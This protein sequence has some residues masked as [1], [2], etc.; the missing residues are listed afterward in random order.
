MPLFA[1]WDQLGNGPLVT[2]MAIVFIVGSAIGGVA[3]FVLGL[4]KNAAE[5]ANLKADAVRNAGD[6]LI[7]VQE[8]RQR[9]VDATEACAGA[10]ANLIELLKRGDT[11]KEDLNMAREEV[12][13]LFAYRVITN[14]LADVEW[15]Y[16]ERRDD[17]NP[18][19]LNGVIN[20]A[21]DEFQRFGK[22]LTIINHPRLLE[23][24]S[25]RP[26]SLTEKT[27]RPILRVVSK[28]PSEIRNEA[29]RRVQ[30]EIEKLL[31]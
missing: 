7:H 1:Q 17:G 11:A 21:I 13:R 29:S 3:G 16:L 12:C 18:D 31:K 10:V 20:D 4:R 27:F 25:R 30:P 28:Y 15:Q 2:A 23:Y 24:L 6:F 9:Y 5:I 22:W 8:S 14:F 26:L 19:E